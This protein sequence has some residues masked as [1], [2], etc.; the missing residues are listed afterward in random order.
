[1]N[2]PINDPDSDDPYEDGYTY[3]PDCREARGD[4]HRDTCVMNA[5]WTEVSSGIWESRGINGF[6]RKCPDGFYE[7][8]LEQG[9]PPV[10][11]AQ[12]L[13]EA[14]DWIKGIA[15]SQARQAAYLDYRAWLRG[16]DTPDARYYER[17]RPDW[18]RNGF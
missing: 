3:C 11:R 4:P 12:S 2:D 10:F 15:L 8:I 18:S 6:I 14:Q 9:R 16:E 5:R 13:E 17:K 1:M 7:H